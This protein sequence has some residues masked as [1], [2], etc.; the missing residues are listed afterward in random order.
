MVKV[1]LLRDAE[2]VVKVEL[3]RDAC[4]PSVEIWQAEQLLLFGRRRGSLDAPV[5]ADPPIEGGLP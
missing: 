2:P 1:E 3:L 5:V 4:S